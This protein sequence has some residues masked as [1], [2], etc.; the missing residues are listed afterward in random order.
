LSENTEQSTSP[1]ATCTEK[2]DLVIAAEEDE[3][4]EEPESSN[5]RV[6]SEEPQAAV[7][8]LQIPCK[9]KLVGGKQIC[10]LGLMSGGH[11]RK[12]LEE[13]GSSFAIPHE[14]EYFGSLSSTDL[15][16]ACEDLSLKVFVASR[17]LARRLEQESKE[18][19]E[20]SVA[21]A[22]SL[23]SRVAELEGR[24]AAEQERNQQLLRAKEDEAKASHAALEVLRLDMENLTSA[25]EDFDA[26]LRDKDARLTEAQN[27]TSR[28]N[29][30]LERYRIEHIRCAEV[31][32]SEVLELLGQCNL[33]A[34]PTLFPQCTVGAFYEWVSTCFDLITMNTKIF[35]ELG[36]AVRFRTLAYY[37]CSLIPADRPSSEKTVSKNDLR[38]L[39]KDYY[40]WLADAELDV[41]HL[42]VLAKNLAKNFMNTFF[43]ERESR[44]TLDESVRLSAQV[45]RNNFYF[46]S[47]PTLVPTYDDVTMLF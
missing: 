6:T 11:E 10:F 27:E 14:E 41:A 1:S 43:A 25:K 36:A 3:E 38:R 28:L 44:L 19:K 13:A 20:L 5:Y 24:L 21:A 45:R 8:R 18:A 37:V 30:V 17:C 47:I 29:S 35:G 34:L 33:D 31:L 2:D 46:C 22:T 40:G 12:F 9:A 26:Q 7:A 4:E 42:P 23:Q 39:T 16:T 32:R 15:T